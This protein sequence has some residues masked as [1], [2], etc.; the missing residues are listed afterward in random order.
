M[1]HESGSFLRGP[2]ATHAGWV[3]ARFNEFRGIVLGQMIKTHQHGAILF[4]RQSR[5]TVF[6]Y[7]LSDLTVDTGLPVSASVV[8]E[9]MELAQNYSKESNF[10]MTMSIVRY[11]DLSPQLWKNGKGVTRTLFSD[12]LANG[13]DWTW[14]ISI[15]EITGTQPYSRYPGIRRSQ[16]ALGPGAVDLVVNNRQIDLP[17]EDII[18]FEG[19]DEVEATPRSEGFLDLNVKAPRENWDPQASILDSAVIEPSAEVLQMLIALHDHC[20]VNGEQLTYLDAVKLVPGSP[21]TATGKFVLTS[22]APQS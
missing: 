15:A 17:V 20:T 14:K 4:S 5:I 19:E 9:M 12:D 3:A 22:L 18:V 6:R 2:M 1:V 21:A 10:I 7:F 13:G 11:A 16:V 8:N